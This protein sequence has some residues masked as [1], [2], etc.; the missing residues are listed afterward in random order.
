MIQFSDICVSFFKFMKFMKIY[1]TI[2][3]HMQIHVSYNKMTCNLI[4]SHL[5]VYPA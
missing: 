3:V 4:N 1:W 2:S 5:Y